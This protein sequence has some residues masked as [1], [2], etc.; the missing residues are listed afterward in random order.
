MN[1]NLSNQR[2][3]KLENIPKKGIYEVPD[4]YFDRLP[5]IIQARVA[6]NSHRQITRPYLRY[7]VQ[8]ALP[9]VLLLVV[10]FIFLKPKEG[11]NAEGLLAS[12]STEELV[13]YLEQSDLTLEE[14][15]DYAEYDDSIV[16]AIEAE[17]FIFLPLEDALDDLEIDPDNL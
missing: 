9:A 12:V 4:G 16:D 15:L 3:K 2:M 10:L 8:Y 17:A 13:A 7:A 5:G 1:E 14:L 11:L 6:E